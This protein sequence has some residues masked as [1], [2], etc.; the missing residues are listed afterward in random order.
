MRRYLILEAGRTVSEIVI[1]R[2]VADDPLVVLE[3]RADRANAAVLCQAAT[4][5]VAERLGAA[6]ARTGIVATV[7]ELPDGEAVKALD[8]L[9]P[10]Y[11]RLNDLA[12]TRGDTIVGVGGGALTDVAGFVGAT[13]L[14][15]VE[16]VYVATTL[17]G[18]VDAA[19]GGK[20]AVNVGGKNLV[21]VFAHPTRVVIDLDLLDQLPPD[22]IRQG[23]AEALKAGLIGDPELVS[24]YA[25]HG[26][27]APLDEVVDRAVGVK[28]AVVSD[29]FREHG[30]RAFLNYGH[31]IGHAIEAESGISHGD[32]VAIGM[33]AAGTVSQ[34]TVGFNRAGE[35]RDLIERLGLPTVAPQVDAARVL[36][37]VNL[38]KKRDVAGTRMVVLEEIGRPA[39]LNVDD[40]TVRAALASVDV[41]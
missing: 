4:R 7:I 20:T 16:A 31:T 32:A 1:D 3:P 40:A 38:D 28:A 34:L 12:L 13:Y 18:A 26:I 6:L 30:N 2:G 29:D 11:R 10:I 35:Q 33:V 14:R 5:G 9:E 41:A 8:A 21:G 15:G 22:L 27:D 24:L 36:D 39:V 37:L 17:L 25:R 23:S 19:I